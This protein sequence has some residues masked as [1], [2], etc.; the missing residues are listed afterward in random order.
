MRSLANIIA[1]IIVCEFGNHYIKDLDIKNISSNSLFLEVQYR[2]QKVLLLV[3]NDVVAK[4]LIALL[5][6]H[7]E[8]MTFDTHENL[9]LKELPSFIRIFDLTSLQYIFDNGSN[10]SSN[11]LKK[12]TLK[13]VENFHS[14]ALS[15]HL[16]DVMKD[17][18]FYTESPYELENKNIYT[19][20]IFNKDDVAMWL[21]FSSFVACS[22]VATEIDRYNVN[23]NTCAIRFNIENSF[24]FE[25]EEDVLLISL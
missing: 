21:H 17:Y 8:G 5:L 11:I 18:T 7:Q 22:A 1:K 12:C 3:Q 4:A 10:I 16:S 14:K 19:L 13:G 15:N 24:D 9:A 25:P 23:S 2:G 6:Y 20:S